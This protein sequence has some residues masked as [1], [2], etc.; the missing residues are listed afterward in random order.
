MPGLIG[1]GDK[2]LA[3]LFAPFLGHQSLGLAVS[4]GPDSLALMLLVARWRQQ[5]A[6]PPAIFV[7]TV[8][9]AL[10]QEAAG[11]AAMVVREA[12]RL[13][14][15]ARALRWDG[16]K[17][18][19]GVSEAA[20]Q[21]RYRLMSQA[22]AE[23]GVE[24][25]VTA[26][27]R[28]DQAETILMRLAHGSGL[29]GLQGMSAE[30][31][32]EGV[33]LLRPLLGIAPEVLRAVVN[34]E[35]VSAAQDPSNHDEDYERVRWRRMLPRLAELGLTSSR[36]GQFGQR[37]QQADTA[38]EFYAA[39]AIADGVRFDPLGAVA[40]QWQWFLD[41]PEAVGTRV[42]ATLMAAAGGE[43]RP[44][45]LGIVETAYAA[46]AASDGDGI[47][48]TALG[49][50]FRRKADT[51]WLVR[52][53]GRKAFPEMRLAPQ[54]AATWDHR[55]VIGNRST[56]LL[57]IAPASQ[58][59]REGAETLLGHAVVAPAEAIRTAPLITG[60]NGAIL[61]LGAY[62]LDAGVESV[63]KAAPK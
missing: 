44:R 57:T 40:M 26:H 61:A 34:A 37:V 32:V 47:G 9:H 38:L 3:A 14:L 55:F 51:I 13:G 54:A 12:E 45:A 41:L 25:L 2:D 52:E 5:L 48:R 6:Q 22:M 59:T 4:G 1:L 33:R 7:Y 27:H 24:V 35:G 42:L 43:Q 10:R 30:A 39:A 63:V 16:E 58:W 31:E 17:P 20:R 19:T 62:S 36:L 18:M 28:D 50:V 49:C 29:H 46:L 56:D 8:D 15:P 23:D 60:P 53:P 21:A 11:E